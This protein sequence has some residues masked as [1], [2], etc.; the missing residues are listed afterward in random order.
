MRMKPPK[1]TAVPIAAMVASLCAL[2]A[3][4]VPPPPAAPLGS[5]ARVHRDGAAA[6]SRDPLDLAFRFA[7]AI[8]ADP[9]D[10]A[11]AQAQVVTELI[12][13][14]RLDEAGERAARI[15]GWRQGTACADIARAFAEQ[16]KPER[17]RTFLARAD[18]IRLSTPDWGGP[19]IAA[20]MAQALA[21]LGDVERSTA[22]AQEV[23]AADARQYAGRAAATIADGLARKGD[24]AGAM[25][26]LEELD[27]E[28]D[29]DVALWRTTGYLDLARRTDVAAGEWSQALSAARRSADGVPGWKRG[30]VLLDLGREYLAR[31]ETTSAR[32]AFAAAAGVIEPLPPTLP[33]RSALLSDL[34]AAWGRLGEKEKARRILDRA[35]R[36]APAAAVIDRPGAWG[37]VAGARWSIGDHEAARSLYGRALTEAEGLV[38]A[39]PRALAAVDI[40]RSLAR[41]HVDVKAGMQGRLNALLAGLRDPW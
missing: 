25:A 14:D 33:T 7:T 22:L 28:R 37:A 11:L 9:N 19:R 2:A 32:E 34:A 30:E 16:R 4:P 21:V 5:P 1:E 27:A 20:H 13:L 23:T 29:Y 35:E 6:V 12:L 8:E 41:N 38:N 18:T 31:K 17:A 36:E 40:C 10:Q 15:K 24:F 26:R 39:R 3:Q